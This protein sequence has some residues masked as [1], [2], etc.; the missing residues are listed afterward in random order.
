[1]KT[2]YNLLKRD[3]I[4]FM[5]CIILNGYIIAELKKDKM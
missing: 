2:G 4:E 5:T 1:M 3:F